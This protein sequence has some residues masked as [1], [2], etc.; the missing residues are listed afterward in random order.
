MPADAV[1]AVSVQV[2][3]QR[4][5][6]AAAASVHGLAERQQQ[7]MPLQ[8]DGG[9]TSRIQRNDLPKHLRDVGLRISRK[10]ER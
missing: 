9:E 2:A 10:P 8:R 5:E 6:A 1:A 7:R 3:E 4:V